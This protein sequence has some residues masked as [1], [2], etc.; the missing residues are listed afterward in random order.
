MGAARSMMAMNGLLRD[1]ARLLFIGEWIGFDL[2]PSVD[3]PLDLDDVA[4]NS[5]ARRPLDRNDQVDR[6]A[7]ARDAERW[8][9]GEAFARNPVGLEIDPEDLRRRL[10][11]GEDTADIMRRADEV[12]A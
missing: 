12:P 1:M 9:A 7:D 3:E 6:F 8:M 10:A 11:S 2:V 5:P 4:N